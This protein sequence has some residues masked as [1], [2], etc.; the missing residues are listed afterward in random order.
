[1]STLFKRNFKFTIHRKFFSTFGSLFNQTQNP[2]EFNKTIL[3][4]KLSIKKCHQ[5]AELG[6]PT[7]WTHSHLFDSSTEKD[8]N[9]QELTPGISKSEFE[10]RRDDYVKHLT[11]YQMFYFS[12]KFSR[13]EKNDLKNKTMPDWVLNGYDNLTID[14]NFISVIPSAMVSF[15]A[16]DVPYNFRQNSDF[17]YLTGFKV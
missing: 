10:Q 11:N 2:N 12:S 5:T 1:M 8:S 13:T 17:L 3:V 16:P 6:Q 9:K 4:N 15:M 14:K 7:F